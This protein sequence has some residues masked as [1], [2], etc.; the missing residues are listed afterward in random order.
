MTAK[1][2]VVGETGRSLS[3]CSGP[4]LFYERFLLIQDDDDDDEIPEEI[5]MCWVR[6]SLSGR[7]GCVFFSSL[8]HDCYE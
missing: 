4:Q 3:C 8:R 1:L 7:E 2:Q 5:Q 6:Y